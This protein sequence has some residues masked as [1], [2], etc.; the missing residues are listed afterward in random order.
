[1]ARSFIY[2]VSENPEMLETLKK[3]TEG[4]DVSF[5]NYTGQQWKEGMENP[6]FRSQLVNGVPSLSSGSSPLTTGNTN[7]S[8]N[9]VNFP[10][11]GNN[12]ERVQKMEELEAHAIEQAIM[13]YKGN[14]T[15]AAKALGI[16]RA[17]LYR[18]V[19]QYHIDP[20]QARRRKVAA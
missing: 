4:K 8:N 13:Q 17:T 14:L 18:K 5:Y 16:G 10:T 20:T 6:F 1:M 9:V 19:K 12:T 15:E 11:N 2:V 7:Y 3:A